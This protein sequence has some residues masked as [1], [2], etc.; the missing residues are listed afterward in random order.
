MKIKE[1]FREVKF[2]IY[3][4]DKN[5]N[6]I[7]FEDSNGYWAKQEYDSNGNEIYYENVSRYWIKRKY[8]SN[9]NQIYVEDSNGDIKDSRPKVELTMDEIAKKFNVPID[10]LKIKKQ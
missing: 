8:D 3:L 9:G 7:Y 2:P 5:G 1:L 10:Q 6:K 4:Y